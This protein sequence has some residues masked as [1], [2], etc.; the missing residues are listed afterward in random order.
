MSVFHIILQRLMEVDVTK[1][2]Q[3]MSA[4]SPLQSHP[5]NWPL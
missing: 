5:S 2:S 4:G 3:Q 1:A